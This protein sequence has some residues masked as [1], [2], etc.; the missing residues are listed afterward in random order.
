MKLINNRKTKW[1]VQLKYS[2]QYIGKTIVILHFINNQF[3]GASHWLPKCN[4]GQCY[5]LII[6]M[7][8][9]LHT[10]GDFSWFLLTDKACF[11]IERCLVSCFFSRSIFLRSSKSCFFF[12]ASS[13]CGATGEAGG[14][15]TL[16]MLFCLDFLDVEEEDWFFAIES[17]LSSLATVVLD[18]RRWG[19]LPLPFRLVF[20]RL[21]DL[22][23]KK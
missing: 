21:S 18:L 12:S 13:A 6:I 1:F 2:P 8:N 5:T 11:L 7:T 4:N 22:E 14:E 3:L 23:R 10:F 15:E 19:F 20:L 9:Q 16:L 17:L